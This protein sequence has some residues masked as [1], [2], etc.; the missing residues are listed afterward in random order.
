M[1]RFHYERLTKIS[2]ILESESWNPA[3]VPYAFQQ[4]FDQIYEFGNMNNIVRIKINT[5]RSITL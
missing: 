2:L 4:L 1:L 3:D 5:A